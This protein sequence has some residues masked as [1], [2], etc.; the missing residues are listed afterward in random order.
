MKPFC[1]FLVLF[2]TTFST[3]CSQTDEAPIEVFPGIRNA[4]SIL[5]QYAAINGIRIDYERK[6]KDGKQWLLFAP[7]FYLDNSPP[8]WNYTQMTGFG[9][10]AYYKL[11]LNH[12]EKKN[13][14]GLS[15]TNVYFTVGPTYQRSKL[16][17][18]EEVPVEY[19]EDGITY[20]GFKT[21]EGSTIFRKFGG[22]ANFG[23]QFAFGR[24]LLDLYAGIG[25]R[26]SIDEDGNMAETFNDDW[27]DIAYSGILLDGGI[28]FGVFIP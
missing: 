19:T 14:N 17:G 21:V 11:F 15:R 20:I 28:R 1:C 9:L 3:A 6:I 27:L 13:P 18:E 4:V 8:D 23:L 10:N 25:F 24:F 5:P 22:T 26:Y 16:K 7:Q 12:S 2:A